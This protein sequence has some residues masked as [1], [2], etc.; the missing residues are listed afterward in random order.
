MESEKLVSTGEQP[1]MSPGMARGMRVTG[2]LIVA[3]LLVA[4][5]LYVVGVLR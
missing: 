2:R 3:H 4:V 5:T 1:S